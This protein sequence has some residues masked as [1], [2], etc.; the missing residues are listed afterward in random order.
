MKFRGTRCCMCE[1]TLLFISVQLSLGDLWDDECLTFDGL[2]P[3]PIQMM[4]VNQSQVKKA[5]QTRT[6]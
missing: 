1:S 5:E 3:K 4:S 6:L 2:L